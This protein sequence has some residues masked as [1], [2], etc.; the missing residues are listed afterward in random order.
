M[1]IRAMSPK[2]TRHDVN[3]I[4]NTLSTADRMNFGVLATQPYQSDSDSYE[5]YHR[6]ILYDE[7]NS[8]IAFFDVYSTGERPAIAICVRSDMQNVGYGRIVA[9][10]GMHWVRQHLSELNIVEWTTKSTNIVSQHLAKRFGF[11][12]Y[13]YNH[14][15]QIITYTIKST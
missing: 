12:K 9:F 11:D 8:P 10:F 15:S 5:I 14:R 13:S 4:V 1:V 3:L 6:E 2:D 7:Y